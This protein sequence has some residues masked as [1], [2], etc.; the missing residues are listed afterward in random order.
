MNI[1]RSLIVKL[2]TKVDAMMQ[3]NT[4]VGS[5]T[6]NMK[7]KVYFTL[8]EPSATNIVAWNCHA[9]DSAKVA[10]DIILGRYLLTALV[11]NLKLSE[12]V[13]ESDDGTLKGSSSPVVDLIMYKFRNLSIRK[14]TP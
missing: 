8:P 6:T 5:I 9:D 14:S 4:Q 7:A 13:I 2:N 11:L 12:H 10:Y 3:C 1:I